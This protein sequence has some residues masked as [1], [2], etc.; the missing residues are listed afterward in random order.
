MLKRYKVLIILLSA[1]AILLLPVMTYAAPYGSNTYGECIYSQGCPADV[2]TGPT[3]SGTLPG[4]GTPPSQ[5]PDS[6]DPSPTDGG[7]PAISLPP[8]NGS[9]PSTPLTSNTEDQNPR[10]LTSPSFG[11]AAYQK[12][13]ELAQKLPEPVAYG[14]PYIL[15]LLL[16]L[17]ALRLL[18]Q[19]KQ[20][21][22]RVAVIARTIK[23][24]KRLGLEKENFIMLS[25]LFTPNRS[26]S[27]CYN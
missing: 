8:Q 11:G 12:L 15:L 14:F 26:H 20:E 18:V 1:S 21:L 13:G 4:E 25:S 23:D 3:D 10:R 22:K 2:I 17:L 7:L 24:K 27:V 5:N 9:T 16:L 19:S 6:S